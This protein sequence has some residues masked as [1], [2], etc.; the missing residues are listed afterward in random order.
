MAF[1][2]P[3]EHYETIRGSIRDLAAETDFLAGLLPAGGTVLDLG[4]GTGTTLRALAAR[5]HQGVG[6]DSSPAFVDYAKRRASDGERYV[7]DSFTTFTTDE[8]FDVV[9]SLF[10]TL[11]LVHPEELPTLL[12]KARTWLRPGG[13]LVLDAAHL[14]NFADSFQPSQVTHHTSADGT[15]V[16]R[17]VNVSINPHR[18]IW[19]NEEAILVGTPD[20]TASIY[21]NFFDQWLL[22]AP[23]LHNLLTAAGF[24][25]VAEYGSFRSTPPPPI[26]RGPLIQ[27]ARAM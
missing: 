4:S 26:G 6:V 15:T 14:L 13:H 24:Q 23:E 17:L 27:V 5:G 1:D 22:T 11:N 7:L 16:T 21:H 19:R 18:A 10:A 12:A 20:G 8:R 2:F 9:C 25:I 3:G